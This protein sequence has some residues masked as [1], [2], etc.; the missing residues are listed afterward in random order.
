MCFCP[1]YSY[2]ELI[3]FSW[4]TK[5]NPA[6]TVLLLV[7]FSLWNVFHSQVLWQSNYLLS[8]CHLVWKLVTEGQKTVGKKLWCIVGRLVEVELTSLIRSH[9]KFI[10]T[11]FWCKLVL[12]LEYYQVDVLPLDRLCGVAFQ[13]LYTRKFLKLILGAKEGK[14]FLE[15]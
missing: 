2:E 8:L 11:H 1:N 5:K 6:H 13:V 15:S 14:P 7:L 10:C 9:F 12:I 3:C 4:Q